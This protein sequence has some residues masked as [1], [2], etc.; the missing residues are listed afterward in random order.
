MLPLLALR[1][2]PTGA[3]LPEEKVLIEF[4]YINGNPGR[5][6]MFIYGP[7]RT[8]CDFPI[9]TDEEFE[10]LTEWIQVAFRL[11]HSPWLDDDWRSTRAEFEAG[12][13]RLQADGAATVGPLPN[14][15]RFTIIKNCHELHDDTNGTQT[16][17][18]TLAFDPVVV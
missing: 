16:F 18:L 6:K 5:V 11:P 17:E 8:P 15:P 4:I 10:T 7:E 2:P 3:P 9:I 13:R 1:Q 12:I 14:G